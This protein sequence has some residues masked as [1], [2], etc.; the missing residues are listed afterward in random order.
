MPTLIK[1]SL[2]FHTFNFPALGHGSFIKSVK[3]SGCAEEVRRKSSLCTVS[4]I[5][6]DANSDRRLPGARCLACS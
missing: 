4:E 1:R 5:D 3:A 2:C 6:G